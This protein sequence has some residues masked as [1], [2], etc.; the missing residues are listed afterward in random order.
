MK[1]PFDFLIN[2]LPNIFPTIFF[3]GR[4]VKMRATP[5]GCLHSMGG[6]G[7]MKW[8]GLEGT[9]KIIWFQPLAMG[10][11]LWCGGLGSCGFLM[12]GQEVMV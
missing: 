6:C 1:L 7:I 9:L 12:V 10:S 3:H 5:G 2:K 11:W 4:Q 8:L